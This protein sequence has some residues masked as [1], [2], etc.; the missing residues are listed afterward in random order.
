[1]G[2]QDR[3]YN[4]DEQG[5][6]PPVMF[7][8]PKL[9]RLTMVLIGVC[10]VVFLVQAF[11][12]RTEFGYQLHYW[13]LLTFNDKLG[14][15]QPWRFITYQYL[16]A[17][18]GH[19]FFNMIGLYF[20]LPTLE[21]MWGWKKALAFYT[22]GGVAAGITYG[23]LSIFMPSVGL[24]GAS[25]AVFAALG[26]VALL[27]PNR[28]LIL[29]VFPLPIRIAAALFGAFFLLSAV[30][31]GDLSNAAHLGGLAFGFFAPYLGGPTYNRMVR[32]WHRYRLHRAVE[33]E[34]NEQVTVDRI[35]DK[36]SHQGMNSLTRSEKKA[37][38]RATERQRLADLA[39]E[40]QWR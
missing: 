7:S 23:I 34:H 29:L 12:R 9:T 21:I 17:G 40:K 24:L 32:K 18:A 3:A 38:Q 33:L 14:L 15:K 22:A 27:S 5:G 25:G 13:G 16:H 39:R 31:D 8:M 4:R 6:I 35:L 1:M 20:F 36:V 19:F 2:W 26:A 28:Q 30:A 37:L 10:L 11:T